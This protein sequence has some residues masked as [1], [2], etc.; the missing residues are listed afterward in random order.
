MVPHLLVGVHR[1]RHKG[2]RGVPGPQPDVGGRAASAG[3]ARRSAIG[4][5]ADVAMAGGEE[6][7]PE[8][9]SAR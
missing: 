5:M 2:H 3:R 1:R 9:F 8:S 7:L 6:P 4:V